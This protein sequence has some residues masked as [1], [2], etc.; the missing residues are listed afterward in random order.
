[1]TG[2]ARE[3]PGQAPAKVELGPRGPAW[4]EHATIPGTG[5]IV[6]QVL[7]AW[8]GDSYELRGTGAEVDRWRLD[9]SGPAPWDRSHATRF[10]LVVRRF[11]APRPGF[12]VTAERPG[13]EVP[14]ESTGS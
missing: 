13:A 11:A 6:W 2:T 4:V 10:V 1:M 5:W 9:V 12:W 3:Y 7:E 14:G 8:H